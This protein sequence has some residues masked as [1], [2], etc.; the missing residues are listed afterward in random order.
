MK[1]RKKFAKH[2]QI[3]MVFAIIIANILD[4][5][6]IICD[7]IMKCCGIIVNIHN[8]IVI[9]RDRYCEYSQ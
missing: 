7:I 1:H 5:I 6:A 2:D 4:I 8:V 3:F 9:I